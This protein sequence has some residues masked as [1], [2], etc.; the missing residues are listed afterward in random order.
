VKLACI[1]TEEGGACVNPSVA[2]ATDRTYPIARPLFM[3]TNGAPQ[4]A[5][6]TYMDW[7]LSDVGQCIIIDKGYAPVRAVECGN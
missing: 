2:T 5:I 1:A 7:I 3:Y 6:K 4:G